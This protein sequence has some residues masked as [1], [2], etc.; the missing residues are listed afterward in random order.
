[1]RTL[2]TRDLFSAY[3][4][5]SK[6]GIR[7]E[8]KEIALKAE[9]E[10]GKA[11]QKEIGFE[12]LFGVLEKATHENAEEEIYK[13]IANIF[14]CEWESVRSMNPVEM[15]DKLEQVADLESW[16]SFF[17]RVAALMQKK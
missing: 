6:I 1:M 7:E 17:K 4:L 10:K 14:E 16:K 5:L 13:F 3:R 9:G 2:E 11:S 15:F 12:F 8:I